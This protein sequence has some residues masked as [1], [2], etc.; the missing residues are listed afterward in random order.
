LTGFKRGLQPRGHLNVQ[1]R[2]QVDFTL[3]VG[4]LAE[5]VTVEARPSSCRPRRADIG[6]P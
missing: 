5:D 1:Q 6:S 2:V 4:D 3:E